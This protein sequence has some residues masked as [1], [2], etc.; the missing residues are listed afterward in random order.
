MSVA[1]VDSQSFE[2]RG[3]KV[4]L[5]L[6]GGG[7]RG[8]YQVGAMRAIGELN[9]KPERCPFPI[10]TGTSAGAINAA[11]LAS[12]ADRFSH[13]VDRLSTFWS[14]M[15][16]HNVYRTDWLSV[17]RSAGHWLGAVLF[18]LRLFDFVQ[19]PILGWLSE[20]ARG[21]EAG[22]G[23]AVVASEVKELAMQTSRATEQVAEQIRA[24]QD[25]TGTSVS[26]LRAIA[27]QIQ[28]LETTSVS[29]ASAV[30]Q[31][32]VAGQDLA[33]SIDMAARGTEHVNSHIGDVRELSLSTGSAASQVLAS[34][35]NLEQ[36]AATLSSQVDRF[37]A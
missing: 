3:K 12:H 27:T 22:R 16:C 5:H 21:G 18:G 30:D 8:A 31:Q 17:I 32:S 11:V 34:A 35:T 1:D 13:G 37:L 6:P 9:P 36:Q 7:A 29:I 26:A 14:A 33:R 24:M 10:F 19:D 28:E 2:D 4:A 23:F 15:R 25:T 20:A